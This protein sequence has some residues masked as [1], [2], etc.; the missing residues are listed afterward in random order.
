MDTISDTKYEEVAIVMGSQLGKTEC[1]ILNPIGYYM[2]QDPCP[3]LVVQPSLEPMAKAF[4]KDRL[5]PMLAESPALRGLVTKS[6]RRNSEDT[7]LHKSFHGGHITI[8]GS[9]SPASLASRPI[10]VVLFDETDRYPASAGNEGDPI[11]LG[12]KRA[13]T[14]WNRKIVKVSSPTIKGASRIW[15]SFEQGDMRYYYVPCPYCQH[16]QTLTW[17][18]VTFEPIGYKCEKC[19]QII[20]E[21]AKN[22]M[23]ANGE[24]RAKHPGRRVASFHLSALYSPW[25]SWES[26]RNEFLSAKNF[27]ELLQVFI[28]TRLAECFSHE[29]EAAVNVEGLKAKERKYE[30]MAEV[31]DGVGILTAGVDVQGDRLEAL[32]VG[33]GVGQESW[34]LSRIVIPGAPEGQQVWDDLD[35]AL[36]HRQWALPSGAL[37]KLRCMMVDSGFSTNAVYDYCRT[38]KRFNVFPSKGMSQRGRALIGIAQRPNKHGVRV[39]S[40]SPDNG[41]DVL[42]GRLKIQEKGPGF[43]NIPDRIPDEAV[44]QFGSETAKLRHHRGVPFFEYHLKKGQRNEMIDMWVMALASLHLLGPAVYDNLTPWVERARKLPPPAKKVET[45]VAQDAAPPPTESPEPSEPV[46]LPPPRAPIKLPRK[47]GWVNR[48]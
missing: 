40:I 25:V 35:T 43:I 48:W 3:I 41:K 27:P 22:K 18:G 38:R 5:S 34:I 6:N 2:H 8:A 29:G 10:R 44:D 17:K 13:S 28:N 1:A 36:L 47:T 33:W 23:L 20:P 42:F 7:L 11:E 14:F 9:N 26:L 45:E 32:L 4:S 39:V 30:E 21:A 15:S 37:L 46:T 12:T 24:W 16:M 31:A 19:E